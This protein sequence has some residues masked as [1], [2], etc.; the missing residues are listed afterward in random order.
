MYVM[1]T[2]DL[3]TKFTYVLITRAKLYWILK[4]LS[5]THC[6]QW[7]YILCF[8]SSNLNIVLLSQSM[9]LLRYQTKGRYHPKTSSDLPADKARYWW[10]IAAVSQSQS[11]LYVIA[12]LEILISTKRVFTFIILKVSNLYKIF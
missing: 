10:S 2:F 5:H 11:N 12:R 9:H 4:I 3:N 6:K 1:Y 7:I 8:K